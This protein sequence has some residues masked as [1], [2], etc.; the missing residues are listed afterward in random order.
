MPGFDFN[1][2]KADTMDKRYLPD[3]SG[4]SIVNLMA[5]IAGRFGHRTGYAQLRQL[6]ASVLKPYKK[7]ILLVLDGMGYHFLQKQGEDSWLKENLHARMTS[8]FPSTTA[9]GITSFATGLPPDRHAITGWFVYL[10]ELGVVSKVLFCQPRYGGGKF[11]EA[12]VDIKNLIGGDPIFD[13]LKAQS[14]MVT[15][16]F[17]ADGPFSKATRGRAVPVPYQDLS[18]LFAGMRSTLKRSRGQAFISA[19]WP[20]IDHLCH[21]HGTDS[22]KVKAHFRRLD[23]KI[24]SFW[25]SV[26][27]EDV[28]LLITADHGLTDTPQQKVIELKDHPDLNQCLSLPLCGE[29]RVA[30]CYIHPDREKQ[31][32]QYVSS[33]LG[34]AGK[35]YSRGQVIQKG[36][37]GPGPADPRLAERIGD[38]VL[39]MEDG[40]CLKDFLLGEEKVYLK[41]HHGGTTFQEMLVPLVKA[42]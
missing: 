11:P 29:P 7:I 34:K 14:F 31:F 28:L 22:P 19:Y 16:G 8:V 6:P 2:D 4:G 9:S 27:R 18:G 21:L 24:A 15:P 5:S 42:R 41:A 39:I 36:F 38:F 30:Y 25:H 32:K 23:K 17:I 40:W 37:Y 1:T 20:E 26:K 33:R 35:L 3:Y 10:K 12:G 13:R